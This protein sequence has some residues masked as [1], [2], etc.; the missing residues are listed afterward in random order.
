MV[1]E[2]VYHSMLEAIQLLLVLV[3]KV[4]DWDVEGAFW[5]NVAAPTGVV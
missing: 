3:V 1:T 4:I 2:W 5:T